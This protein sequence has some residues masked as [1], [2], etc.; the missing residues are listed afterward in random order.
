MKMSPNL[1]FH[2]V[3]R[4][5]MPRGSPSSP[6][7]TLRR[8]QFDP[9]EGIFLFF[10]FINLKFFGFRRACYIHNEFIKPNALNLSF[11]F[12]FKYRSKRCHVTCYVR[13]ESAHSSICEW[14]AEI[15][16]RDRPFLTLSCCDTARTS[17]RINRGTTRS[18]IV[19]SKLEGENSFHA[20]WLT[21]RA[22]IIGHTCNTT[23]LS[24][25]AKYWMLLLSAIISFA[26]NVNATGSGHARYRGNLAWA[27]SLLALKLWTYLNRLYAAGCQQRGRED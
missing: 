23:D 9:I 6:S 14:G 1:R 21:N 10:F 3:R 26:C 16:R 22:L 4:Q 17:R 5:K 7:W 15:S 27:A 19:N 18:R 8:T 13:S 12:F 2:R 24:N 25:D 20:V 11:Q